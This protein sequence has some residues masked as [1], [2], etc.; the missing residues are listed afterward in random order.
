MTQDTGLDAPITG[1]TVYRDGAR[2]QRTAALEAEPGLRPVKI[3]ELPMN[4]DLD[5]VRVA[6]FG[7]DLALLNVEV[8]NL[9]RTEPLREEVSQLRSAL[10]RVPG[11]GPAP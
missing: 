2:I 6:V 5:S 9:V 10:E 4:V 8:H 11:R 7:Q 1:V 3:A